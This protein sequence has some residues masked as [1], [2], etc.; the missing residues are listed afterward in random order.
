MASTTMATTTMATARVASPPR[1][2][3]RNKQKRDEMGLLLGF[4][5]MTA[6]EEVYYSS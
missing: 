4:M 6:R 3:V 5:N 1:V 2:L